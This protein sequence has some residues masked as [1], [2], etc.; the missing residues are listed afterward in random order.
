MILISSLLMIFC[1]VVVIPTKDGCF[2]VDARVINL[3]VYVL[4]AYCYT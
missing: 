2:T 4:I 1:C 3:F